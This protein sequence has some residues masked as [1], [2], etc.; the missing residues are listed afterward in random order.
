MLKRLYWTCY[1]SLWL[2]CRPVYFYLCFAKKQQ[3]SCYRDN[4]LLK[5]TVTFVLSTALQRSRSVI[6]YV[7]IIHLRVFIIFR[8]GNNQ[9]ILI[10]GWLVI[11]TFYNRMN[12]SLKWYNN[13]MLFY[14]TSHYPYTSDYTLYF[15]IIW[16]YKYT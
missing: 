5:Y 13:R 1:C 3:M 15:Y 9:I 2:T 6:Y 10:I 7:I 11:D 16:F 8:D 14:L 12:F 4:I